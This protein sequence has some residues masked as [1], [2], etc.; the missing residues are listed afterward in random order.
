MG[1]CTAFFRSWMSRYQAIIS[2]RIKPERVTGA[3][4]REEGLDR[5][6]AL[7]RA[8]GAIAG[9]QAATIAPPA[10]AQSARGPA[11]TASFKDFGAVGDG[12]ADD[13]RAIQRALASA[14]RIVPDFAT[15]AIAS[16]IILDHDASLDLSGTLLRRAARSDPGALVMV[17]V[18]NADGRLQSTSTVAVDGNRDGA[19][20]PITGVEVVK[21]KKAMGRLDAAALDCDV[22][23][24]V[25]GNVEYARI[26]A[27]A[28]GCTLG[29]D[30][31]SPRSEKATPDE[32]MLDC[33]AHDCG[34]F[35]MTSGERKM[36]G[37]IAFACEQSDDWG[38]RL[39]GPGWWELSGIIRG[40]GKRRGGG[41]FVDGPQLRGNLK[42][43]GGSELNCS[44]AADIAAARL[45]DFTLAANGSY[46]G[47]VRIAGGVQG[48]LNLFLQNAPASKPG[49]LLG[50]NAGG[51]ARPL[52]GLIIG[53]G[54][55]IVAGEGGIALELA[56]CRNCRIS[57]GFIAGA[58]V[59]SP[60]AFGNRIEVP[61]ANALGMRFV[62]E[63]A[64]NDNRIVFAGVY[65]L[66][67]LEQLN[68]G[69]PLEGF[70][71]EMCREFALGPA[72][73]DGVAW[74]RARDL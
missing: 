17:A 9:L 5:R 35:L 67:E 46:A 4:M 8:G 24:S 53:A 61:R 47:G 73:F 28:E 63:R 26:S 42:V 16:T 36:S 74:R 60:R 29:V 39:Q 32:L 30:L 12:I 72:R 10:S 6:R 38:V 70:E 66:S 71:A 55:R 45:E 11:G 51:E 25:S 13:S 64:E 23:V 37:T 69:R 52:D 58:C 31:R 7:I 62:N 3:D 34:T 40:C 68:G 33:F 22:G 19:S 41:L 65:D 50:A 59:I 15:Y 56:D 2:A 48:R 54:S 49:L 14:K 57:A 43:V 18:S 27:H 21:L 44:W 1:G 20:A